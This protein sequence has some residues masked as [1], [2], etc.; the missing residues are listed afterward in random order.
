MCAEYEALLSITL[1]GSD[2]WRINHAGGAPVEVSPQTIELIRTGLEFGEI[3]GGLF[4]VTIGRLSRLWDF[5]GNPSV[6]GANEL[7]AARSTVD[8]RQIVVNTDT[9]RMGDPEAWIDLGG[10]AKGY[11]AGCIAGFLI[12]R[13]VTG[14]VVD[15]GGDVAIVGGKPDGSPWKVGVRRP[16][17][18][19]SELLGAIET[20]E[21]SIVTS[22]VYERGFEENG[23]RYHH[24]LDPNTGMPVDSDVVSVTVVAENAMLGDVMSTIIMLVGSENALD[25]LGQTPGFFGALLVLK[26]GELLQL[27]EIKFIGF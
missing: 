1:E 10:I 3:S 24:I 12:G 25:T 6:P 20:G 5:S 7:E 4:D 13:G 16:F 2:V 14:A 8:Y 26:S 19:R 9:V 17:G 21:A 11:I 22:G 15:L 18:E 23:V 27:G